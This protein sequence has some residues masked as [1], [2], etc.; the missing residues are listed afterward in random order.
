MFPNPDDALRMASAIRYISSPAPKHKDSEFE[1]KAHADH[2]DIH[3]NSVKRHK[4][5]VEV[6]EIQL[7]IQDCPEDLSWRWE[8]MVTATMKH[9]TRSHIA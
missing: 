7:T 3:V 5:S 6:S 1:L 4:E 8:R 2:V 9:L